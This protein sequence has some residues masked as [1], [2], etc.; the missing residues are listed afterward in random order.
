MGLIEGNKATYKVNN[1]I[2][3][4]L[5]DGE[6]VVMHNKGIVKITDSRMKELIMNWDEALIKETSNYYLKKLFQSDFKAAVEF[7]ISNYI[8]IEEPEINYNLK[9][10]YLITNSKEVYDLSD[11]I[12]D[13]KVSN[14]AYQKKFIAETTD[15][16]E[17]LLIDNYSLLIVFLNPYSKELAQTLQNH[18]IA[19]EGSI[20]LMSYVYNCNF[21]M[22]S[23]Y[24]PQL[25]NPC[26][27]CHMGHIEAQLRINST[28]NIT[29]QQIID[30]IYFNKPNFP[31]YSVLSKNN[32]M[33]IATLLSNKISKFITLENGEL[34]YPEELQECFMLDLQTNKMQTDYS[35]HWELCDCYE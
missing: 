9:N 11:N 14:L 23:L 31:I 21:Y 18:V 28:G 4:E 35:L 12:F 10:I 16:T 15:Y 6:L 20:L 3:Y 2:T 33:N 24:F 30:S 26:H 29:Y 34:I 1:Y 27:L 32:I 25:K 17:N 19:S 7:L 8:L 22:D 13:S 5:D